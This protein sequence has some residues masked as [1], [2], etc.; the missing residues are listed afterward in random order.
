MN[1]ATQEVKPKIQ[2]N[3]LTP[4]LIIDNSWTVEKIARL[5]APKTWQKVFAEAKDELKDISDILEDDKKVNGRW[6]PDNKDLFKAFELTPLK[7]I[8]VVIIGQDPYPGTNP[9]RSPQ[10]QGMSFSVKR[11][12]PI[13]QS[14]KNI[15]KELK[16]NYPDISIPKHGDLCAWARQGILLLNSCLTVRPKSAGC[17]KELWLGFIKKII[18][19]VL[20]HNP[21][22]IFVFWGRKAQKI[23]K[24]V[25]ERATVLESSHPSPL[26]AYRGFFGCGHFKEINRLLVEN[27]KS[28]INWQL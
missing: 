26:S 16:D 4:E 2:L 3:I 12:T 14:L 17:H 5:R 21:G 9:D 25:G 11:G 6:Y 15:Y 1:T 27:G 8:K 7:G 10:A 18:N 22:C 20:D 24:M 13:P 19:A 28:P 23:K